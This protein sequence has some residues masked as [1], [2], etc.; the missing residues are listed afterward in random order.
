MSDIFRAD[1]LGQGPGAY[2]TVH[3]T[4][5]VSFIIIATALTLVFK[6]KPLET[7]WRFLRVLTIIYFINFIGRQVWLVATGTWNAETALPL[8]LCSYMI[9]FIP[10]AVYG[11]STTAMHFL[12][13]VGFPAAMMALIFPADWIND[14]PVT[15]YRAFET[16]FSHE[17]I[18]FIGI[19]FLA[20]GLLKVDIRKIKELFI[21]LLGLLLVS[22]TANIIIGGTANFMFV[23]EAPQI[24]PFTAIEDAIGHGYLVV[25]VA[26][27]VIM[28]LI[29]FLPFYHKEAFVL[30]KST[31]E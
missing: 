10:W 19:Y 12:Y 4:I 8:H 23:M 2:G 1:Y 20:S 18:V 29:L 16:I 24:F 6:S 9:I 31:Q 7:Q 13:G 28:W 14:F 21:T 3:L 17:L 26:L 5:L 30:T 27:L 15:T 25:F 22:F 11:K